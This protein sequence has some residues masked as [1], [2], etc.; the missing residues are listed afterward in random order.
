MRWIVAPVAAVMLLAPT[1]PAVAQWT[2]PIPM[3]VWPCVSTSRSYG[4][5]VDASGR[6]IISDHVNARLLV[7]DR[8]GSLL[9][10]WGGPGSGPGQFHAVQDVDVTESG[11]IYVVDSGNGRVQVLD[12]AGAFLR[13]IGPF[14]APANLYDPTYLEV[15]RDGRVY[16]SDSQHH[17]IAAYDAAGQFRF[18]WGGP[19]F[20]T[21]GL[22]AGPRGIAADAAGDLYVA[23]EANVR[24]QKFDADGRFL[25]QWS[26]SHLGTGSTPV[27]RGVFVDD[28]DRVYVTDYRND[29][30]LV[31]M[32]SGSL[33]GWWS[34]HGSDGSHFGP[35][36]LHVD[37]HGRIVVV[38]NDC[39]VKVYA[40]DAATAA[41]KVSWGAVKRRYR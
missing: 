22:F 21:P 30:V 3:S 39:R 9:A 32:T 23:D 2:P 11:E 40:R 41:Q 20:G 14:P 12:G 13:S 4:V 31:Y 36:D 34:T 1:S 15:M 7:R 33:I 17:R 25:A 19:G 16:V 24:I 37:R 10:T 8:D 6:A 18:S 29:L 38:G 5:A 35:N 28:Q 27:P 26:I